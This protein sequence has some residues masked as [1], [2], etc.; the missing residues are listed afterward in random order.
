MTTMH[1]ERTIERTKRREHI[2]VNREQ[3]DSNERMR[4]WDGS[5][6]RQAEGVEVGCIEKYRPQSEKAEK[7]KP[8]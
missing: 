2:Q 1:N 7:G 5:F 4:R 6:Q 3:T 8:I